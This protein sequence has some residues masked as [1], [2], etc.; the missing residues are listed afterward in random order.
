MQ[1]MRYARLAALVRAV[2]KERGLRQRDVAA[3]ARVSQQTVSRVE[4]GSLSEIPLGTIEAVADVLGITLDL[5]ARWR[6]SAG[7]RLLDRAHAELVEGVVAAIRQNGW[8][9]V[10]KFSFNRNGERGAVDV[11]GWHEDT[12]SLLLVEVKSRI[13]DLQEMLGTLDRKARVVPGELAS[14]RGWRAV[15]LGVV[16]VLPDRSSAR[17][18]VA[19]HGAIF[20]AAL[21]GRTHDVTAW[22][23]GPDRDLRAVWFLRN[24]NVAG[25]AERRR[26]P[27]PAGGP[28][29]ARS[30][31]PARF[32]DSSDGPARGE[33]SRS[34]PP[35]G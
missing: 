31:S 11:V 34:H 4:C 6:G 33:S 23:R 2:R 30:G 21:P 5:S 9:A 7:D 8:E 3:R 10:V 35:H 24:T 16:V 14:D 25:T 32:I 27:R 29:S 19:R 1:L 18:A 13:V 22:L 17:D 12:R 26:A 28:E 20:R 15:R